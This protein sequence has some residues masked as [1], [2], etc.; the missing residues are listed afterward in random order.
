MLRRMTAIK[1][2]KNGVPNPMACA[3]LTPNGETDTIKNAAKIIKDGGIVAFPTE[4]VYGLGANAFNEEAVAR[5]YRVKGRPG[6]NPLILHINTIE[7]AASLTDNLSNRVKALIHAFWPGPLTLVLTKTPALPPWIGGHPQNR[8][9]TLAVRSPQNPVARALIEA[10]GCIIAAP[11]ANKAGTP[12]PTCAAHVLSDFA[13]GEIDVIIDGDETN[14]GLESTVVDMTDDLP[15]ILR[16]GS[17]TVEMIR[18]VAGEAVYDETVTGVPR[19]PGQK[20]RHYAPKAPMT[21]VTGQPEKIA[22]V[23]RSYSNG[24]RKTGILA[25]NQTKPLYDGG[26]VL[27]M[28]DRNDL[29]GIAQNL[30][31]CLRCF[32]ELGVEEIYAE[33]VPED[34][35]GRAIMNRMVKAAEGRVM[36][37]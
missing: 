15:R 33:A 7:Q 29:H 12:S 1:K 4:T 16:P 30:Y 17:I 34:G 24:N 25:T 28:G 13:P 21:V 23:I 36:H 19:S 11:S 10:S 37:G 2:D 27:S 14:I 9:Q 26:C 35:I 32:D 18:E 3:F 31:A 20:Y 22:A 6:D 5:V 8:T